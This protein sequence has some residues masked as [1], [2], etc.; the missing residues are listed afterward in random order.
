V[1]VKGI[2]P[3]LWVARSGDATVYLFGTV[4]LLVTPAPWLTPTIQSAFAA[5]RELWVET[6]LEDRDALHRAMQ[7]RATE[8]SYALASHVAPADWA[9]VSGLLAQCKVPAEEASHLRPWAVNVMLAGCTLQASAR[10]SDAKAGDAN[11]GAIPPSALPDEYLVGMAHAAGMKVLGLETPEQ[12]IAALADVPDA[13]QIAL[14]RA[15]LHGGGAPLGAGPASAAALQAAWMGGDL[16]TLGSDVDSSN[17]PGSAEI[18]RSVYVVRN[19][20]FADG[21]ARLLGRRTAAF[22]AIGSGHFAGANNV[23]AQLR[24]R[25]FLVARVE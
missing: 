20:R 21:I 5:S 13:V 2:G 24:A 6:D 22:V 23:L 1:D 9:L 10:S 11:S 15:A 25:G 7:A 16:Q 17:H 18:Y 8:V 12:Q 4:H 3:A 19:E 14:L